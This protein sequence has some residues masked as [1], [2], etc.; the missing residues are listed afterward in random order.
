MWPQD[1]NDACAALLLEAGADTE[2]LT[3]D[4]LSALFVAAQF[5]EAAGSNSRPRGSVPEL[6]G[7][8]SGPHCSSTLGLPLT[9]L[10]RHAVG[11]PNLLL[12]G[13]IVTS[14]RR[15]ARVR[16]NEGLRRPK[17]TRGEGARARA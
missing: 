12:S 3:S 8:P 14:D 7:G 6:S 15:S 5:G 4:G 9:A 10:R 17:G 13:E 1:D 16:A 2:A 11:R